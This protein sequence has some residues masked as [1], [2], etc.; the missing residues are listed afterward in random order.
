MKVYLTF[1]Q[2][3]NGNN[4]VDRVFLNKGD[5]SCYVITEEMIYRSKTGEEFKKNIDELIEEH[6]VIEQLIEYK[7]NKD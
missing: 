7:L 6:E 2:D 1:E 4:Q 3:E 5:A